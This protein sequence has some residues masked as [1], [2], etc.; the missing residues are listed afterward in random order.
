MNKLK[1]I[2]IV[3]GVI[4]VL[5]MII[6]IITFF[7]PYFKSGIRSTDTFDKVEYLKGSEDMSVLNTIKKPALSI[8]QINELMAKVTEI[9]TPTAVIVRDVH[10]TTA[11]IKSTPLNTASKY[12]N[13]ASIIYIEETFLGGSD[14]NLFNAYLISKRGNIRIS[15]FTNELFTNIESACLHLSLKYSFSPSAEDIC[16]KMDLIDQWI[17]TIDKTPDYKVLTNK[18]NSSG[19]VIRDLDEDDAGF[20]KTT[21]TG[22]LVFIP[23]AGYYSMYKEIT[24]YS[25]SLASLDRWHHAAECVSAPIIGI[26]QIQG[27]TRSERY[28]YSDSRSRVN[29]HTYA[30]RV[31][32]VNLTTGKPL[33]YI[34]VKHGIP[35]TITSANVFED[36]QGNVYFNEN[37]ILRIVEERLTQ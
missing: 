12:S 11:F 30:I 26:A 34:T 31:T 35:N 22:P 16:T 27:Y 14:N 3:F 21:V 8:L 37:T 1:W 23:K 19:A 24:V 4:V 33:G 25:G 36:S 5:S 18:L 10:H 6:T 9:K 13:A 7:S 15:L 29:L 2:A 17:E 28:I 32:F 20:D